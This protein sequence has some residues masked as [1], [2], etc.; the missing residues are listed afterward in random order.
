MRCLSV[1]RREAITIHR[2]LAKLSSSRA[3]A[4]K[5]FT[6]EDFTNEDFTNEDFT[7]EDF[8][9]EDFTNED[10]TNEDFTNEDLCQIR[11]SMPE[12]R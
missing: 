8:T 4:L 1:C 11:A 12:R 5:D 7:N 3:K 9:N 2:N 10:F 6:N